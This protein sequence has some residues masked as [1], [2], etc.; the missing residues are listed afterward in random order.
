MLSRVLSEIRMKCECSP[1]SRLL[2][3]IGALIEL[4]RSLGGVPTALE[5]EQS[6]EVHSKTARRLAAT[7][8]QLIME[9]VIKKLR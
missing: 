5:I 1:N 8:E 7:L 9:H 4:A 3:Y 6:L 2:R